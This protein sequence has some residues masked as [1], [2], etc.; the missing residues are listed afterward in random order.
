MF[1]Q[2]LKPRIG[3]V[4]EFL[5]FKKMST[6]VNRGFEMSWDD[7]RAVLGEKTQTTS[8]DRHYIYHPAWAARILAR[9]KPKFHVDISSS[10]SFCAIVS[11][12][13]P[14]K[15]YDYRPANL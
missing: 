10:L 5:Q 7:K 8:F 4:K 9:T 13:I 6:G 12:F 14:V 2:F 15:F 11:A 3:F 1:D